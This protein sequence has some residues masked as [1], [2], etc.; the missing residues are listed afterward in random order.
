M[1]SIS[2]QPRDMEGL[3]NTIPF[4]VE[5]QRVE[6]PL[7]F[8]GEKADE[9]VQTIEMISALAPDSSILLLIDSEGGSVEG[10]F[11]LVECLRR[12]TA[13]TVGFV[14][15]K[16]F[17]AASIILQGCDLRIASKDASLHFHN[18]SRIRTSILRPT[19]DEKEF[20]DQF[21]PSFRT[22]IAKL[23]TQQKKMLEILRSRTSRS[24]E[25]ILEIMNKEDVVFDSEGALAFGLIDRVV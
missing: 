9:I 13:P 24:E 12:I 14:H 19:T 7:N 11:K 23:R 16:A 25:E 3:W 1:T 6:I 10:S 18:P 8:S 15:N 21:I 5:T 17:S 2:P 4:I 20:M 22:V